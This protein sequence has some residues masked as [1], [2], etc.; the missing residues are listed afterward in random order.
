MTPGEFFLG[1]VA[2]AIAVALFMA[3][4]VAFMTFI[5]V[6][7]GMLEGVFFILYLLG[8]ACV[9]GFKRLRRGR[10]R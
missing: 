4:V 5:G 6:L 10:K 8:S 7:L 2:F 1:I 3:M 9:A